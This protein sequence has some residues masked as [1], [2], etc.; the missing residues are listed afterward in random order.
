M[1]RW[2]TVLAVLCISMLVVACSG[3]DSSTQ[4]DT[5]GHAP[6][7]EMVSHS[8]SRLSSEDLRGK[9]Y[10]ANFIWTNCR[11]TCPT[12][13]LQM[14]LLQDRLKQQ[15]LLGEQVVLLS[16]SFDPERDTSERLNRYAEIFKAEPEA[17]LFLTGTPD[18]VYDVVTRGFGVSYRAFTPTDA[19]QSNP[20]DEVTPDDGASE[21]DA[22]LADVTGAGDIGQLLDIDYSI[23]F[24]HQNV[25][26]LVDDEGEIRQYY[27][28]VFLDVDRVMSDVK[29]L[30]NE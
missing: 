9:V 12:L 10:V 2:P 17:W 13:S 5:F 22:S 24:E 15:G 19:D 28:N 11:D 21:A 7:W 16:F 14:A 3:G 4:L 27:I 26:V 30:L 6:S 20:A 23:D 18:E 8:G 29:S 25:F 1:T